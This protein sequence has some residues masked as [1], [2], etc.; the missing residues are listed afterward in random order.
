MVEAARRAAAELGVTNAEF[1]VL[2]AER[3]ELPDASV[4]GVL[5]RFGYILRGDPPPALARDPPRAA[6]RRP[7]R[8]LGLGRARA[9]PVDDGAG[10]VMVERGHLSPPTEAERRPLARRTPR[11]SPRS[12]RGGFA[13][14]EI[15]ELPVTYRFADADE[16]WFFVS[17]LRGP[18][19]L[20]IAGS[21]T[22]ERAAVRAEIESRR[23]PDA[24]G[25]AL[26]GRQPE[27]RHV[28]D[29]A[30]TT[31]SSGTTSRPSTSP[32]A[33]MRRRRR[34]SAAKRRRDHRRS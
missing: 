28:L 13:E 9:E 33:A 3:I 22:E 30:D 25:F 8:V 23:P 5:Y 1:R 12:S 7:A 27:R 15:E 26:G 19:A 18:I 29:S 6:P 10:R 17:E 20:A 32:T 34:S 2:D 11:R 21:T 16:L 14:P 24:D 4:D 31:S